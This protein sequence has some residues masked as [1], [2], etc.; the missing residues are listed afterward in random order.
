MT[1]ADSAPEFV[2]SVDAER[3]AGS[4]FAAPPA[5]AT[6]PSQTK[7]YNVTAA[8]F[9]HASFHVAARAYELTKQRALE[10]YANFEEIV[11]DSEKKLKEQ[12]TGGV[13]KSD[14]Y[15][16]VAIRLGSVVASETCSVARASVKLAYEKTAELQDPEKREIEKN[17]VLKEWSEFRTS[18]TGFFQNVADEWK[19][20]GQTP[21]PS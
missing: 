19:R 7:P 11:D 9:G 16:D 2:S 15:L 8:E 5:Q 18:A 6:E 4:D 12:N 17:K 1:Q 20:L 3:G 13:S 14:V 10:A 21:I